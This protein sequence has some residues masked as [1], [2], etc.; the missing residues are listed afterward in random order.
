MVAGF[1]EM[2]RLKKAKFPGGF[3]GRFERA[4]SQKPPRRSIYH[5]QIKKWNLVEQSVRDAATAAK[6]NSA[7]MITHLNHI[8]TLTL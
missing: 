5:D 7:L 6:R 1:R 3:E 8:A 4:F 2:Q